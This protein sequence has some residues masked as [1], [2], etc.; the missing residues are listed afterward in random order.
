[1][2][3]IIVGFIA[4]FTSTISLLPQIYRT[5]KTKSVEDL[6]F[7]MLINFTICSI[8]WVLYGILT[9]TISVWITNIIMTIFSFILLILKICYQP[10]RTRYDTSNN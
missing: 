8:S 10:K 4:S 2:V 1:M 9:N 6:S 7:L 5:Y 3:V